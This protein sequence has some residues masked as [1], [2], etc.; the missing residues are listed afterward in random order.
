[1]TGT[2]Y[3]KIQQKD[4]GGE[5]GHIKG[6][7]KQFGC[8]IKGDMGTWIFGED[9]SSQEYMTKWHQSYKAM[10]KDVRSLLGCEY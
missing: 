3:V 1:M 7:E 2:R 10:R 8:E 4:K 5:L 6:C 9:L